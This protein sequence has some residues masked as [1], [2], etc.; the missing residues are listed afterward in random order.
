MGGQG[1]VG[2]SGDPKGTPKGPQRDGTLCWYLGN[3]ELGVLGAVQLQFLGD[4]S[5]GDA[6]VGEADHADACGE[7]GRRE[8]DAAPRACP[9]WGGSPNTLLPV[10]MTLCLSRMIRV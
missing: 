6:G 5:Q 4:V 9:A 10:L 1:R 7:K 3:D 2:D 8:G